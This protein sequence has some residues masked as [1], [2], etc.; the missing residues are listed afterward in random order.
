MIDIQPRVGEYLDSVYPSFVVRQRSVVSIFYSHSAPSIYC[1]FPQMPPIKLLSPPPLALLFFWA[2]L[3]ADK[4]LL[5][6][7]HLISSFN[8][9]AAPALVEGL[10]S[11]VR[12]LCCVA[13]DTLLACI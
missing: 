9:I 13:S 7:T 11:Q 5:S 6:S 2:R 8:F 1:L 10:W 12:K 4:S 3:T